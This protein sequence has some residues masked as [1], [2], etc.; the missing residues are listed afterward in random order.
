MRPIRVP[1]E[2]GALDRN[3]QAANRK[4]N[5]LIARH[6]SAE[7]QKQIGDVMGTLN[8]DSAFSTMN[9]MEEKIAQ[10]EATNEAALELSDSEQ[11]NNLDDQ[12]AQL[13]AG[14]VDDEL[15]AL[16]AS[17]TGEPSPQLQE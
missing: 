4:R 9:R 1:S 17:L 11:K 6:K 2:F 8:N 13:A 7:A 10:L 3:I 16:K 12:M 15:A 14:N 5:T